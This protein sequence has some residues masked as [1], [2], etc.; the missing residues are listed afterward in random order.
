MIYNGT[1][2]VFLNLGIKIPDQLRFP[3]APDVKAVFAEIAEEG[4]PHFGLVY[5]VKKAHRRIPVLP[6]EWRR[7]ACQVKGSATAPLQMW[8]N[9]LHGKCKLIHIKTYRVQPVT[10]LA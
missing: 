5:N 7:L 6:S 8:R 10:I 3:T 9:K 4:G 1:N 2:G